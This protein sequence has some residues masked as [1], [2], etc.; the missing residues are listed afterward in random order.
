MYTSS[1][2]PC[3]P[4]IIC[5]S[6][7][8]HTYTR[9]YELAP[10]AQYAHTPCCTQ[11]VMHRGRCALHCIAWHGM[12][13]HGMAWPAGLR[14]GKRQHQESLDASEKH[15]KVGNT[16]HDI[17]NNSNTARGDGEAWGGGPACPSGQGAAPPLN[18]WYEHRDDGTTD[19]RGAASVLTVHIKGHSTE[20]LQMRPA[21]LSVLS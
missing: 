13:W 19:P 9:T 3:T 12:A 10:H 18:L 14:E 21:S 5:T 1:L 20:H 15:T 16:D 17:Q 4:Q 2:Q 7:R 6:C 11:V 8:V